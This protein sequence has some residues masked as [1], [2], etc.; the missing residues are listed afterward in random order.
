MWLGGVMEIFSKE[1]PVGNII[2]ELS[3]QEINGSKRVV[4]TAKDDQHRRLWRTPIL[5]NGEI[6]TYESDQDA[7]DD[8][9]KKVGSAY[10]L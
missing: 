2:I 3:I 6:K 9:E 7:I 5:D 8:A 1:I 4:I 10:I